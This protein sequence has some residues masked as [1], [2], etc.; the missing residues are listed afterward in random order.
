MRGNRGFTLIELMIVVAIIAIIAALAVPNLLSAR[1]AANESAAIST[2]RQLMSS[3]AQA[4]AAAVIDGDGDGVGEFANFGE[5]A[6]AAF[7]RTYNGTTQIVSATDKMKPPVASSSFGNV[8]SA[9]VQRSGYLFQIWLPNAAGLGVAEAASGGADPSNLPDPDGC[10]A[11]W[12]A[13]AWPVSQGNS[14]N[15]VFFANQGGE[16]LQMLNAGGIY[17][18]VAAPSPSAAFASGGVTNSIIQPTANTLASK[19]G[20]DGQVWTTVN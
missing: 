12:C 11:T 2:L 19:L 3:Q 16:L 18:G 15:R 20:M 13:Y 5:L 10:E 7:V 8:V 9:R 1:Q 17:T 4:K 14:S 6:G